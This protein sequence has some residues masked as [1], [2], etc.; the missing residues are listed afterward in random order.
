MGNT[1]YADSK[2]KAEE[3]LL[4][5]S[6][7]NQVKLTILRPSLIAG[8]NPPGNLGDLIKAIERGIYFNIGGGK[9]KKS[10]VWAEDFANIVNL[11][12]QNNG[13]IYN[14][15]DTEQP[16]FGKIAEIISRKLNK[17]KPCLL[18]TSRCV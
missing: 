5:W 15:A 10:I 7:A 13:G 12:T 9:A 3:F 16:T 2:R 6:K 4:E 11:A 8:K 18:Y 1:P 14:V 17:N